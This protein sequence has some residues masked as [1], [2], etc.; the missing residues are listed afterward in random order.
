MRLALC[1]DD[2]ECTP[3]LREG[4]VY[5]ISAPYEKWGMLYVNVP[6]ALCST[7]GLDCYWARRFV[8]INDPDAITDD[9]KQEEEIH[10]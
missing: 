1:I 7:T 6:A 4:K 8:P 9:V 10:A 3:W 2:D 5:E